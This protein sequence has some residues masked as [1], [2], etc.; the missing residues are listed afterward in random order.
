MIVPRYHHQLVPYNNTD[1]ILAIGGVDQNGTCT[2]VIE[3]YN[4]VTNNWT[5]SGIRLPTPRQKFCAVEY[6]MMIY[7]IGGSR[8]DQSSYKVFLPVSDY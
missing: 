3:I 5:D 7:V 1:E 8:S 6:Q 2:D 4:A